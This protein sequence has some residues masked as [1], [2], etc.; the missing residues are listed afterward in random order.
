MA[1]AFSTHANACVAEYSDHNYYMFSVFNRDQTSPAY[2]YDIA[3]YWQ[4]YAGNTSSINLSFYRWNKEDIKKIAQSKKDAGMLSYL[5]NLNAYLDACEKLNP[6]AWNYA[7]KQERLQIQ[8]S[9]TR[10]NN[11]A[12]I[13]SQDPTQ[14]PVCPAPYAHQHDE[15]IPPAEHHLL[16]CHRLP[17][18]EITMARGDAQHLCPG[19]MEDGKTSAGTGYLCR[20]GRYGKHQGARPKLSQS[21]RHSEHLFQESEL[22]YAH[23]SGAGFREQLSADDRQSLQRTVK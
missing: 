17:T 23:L 6:N 7:S 13:Y 18:S 14:E 16:E 5:R 1:A 15:R 4:K 12:K 19:F 9:L 2:L 21:C 22:G 10:L 8:Q 11:A 3:S 20:A